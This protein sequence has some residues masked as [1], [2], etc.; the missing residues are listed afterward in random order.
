MP[1]SNLKRFFLFI[2]M[3]SILAI[4]LFI[5]SIF[6][7]ILPSFEKNIMEGKKEMIS[8][9]TQSVCS[10]IEEYQQEVTKGL[11]PLDSAQ[12]L[13]VE[14]ISQIRY[15]DE[16]KDY[17]WIIDKQPVMIMHPYRPELIGKDLNHYKDPDGKLVFV[18]SVAVV[19]KKGEGFIDYMWQRK[20]DSTRI[21]PKLSYVKEVQPWGWIVGTGIYLEDVRLEIGF[22]K[23]GLLRVALLI[24]LIISTILA[25]IIRQSLDIEK[26][27]RKAE[28][29]LRLSREKYKSLVEASTEG[30]LMLANQAFVFSNMKFSDLSG[31]D[32]AEVR[33][34]NFEQLF[35]VKWEMLASEFKDPKSS[36]SRETILKCKDGSQKEV[37]ISAS[38]ITY[39]GQ[40]G[41]ILVTKEVSSLMQFEKES[42]QLAVEL[43][44]SLSVMNQPLHS[45]AGEIW[46]CQADTSIRDAALLMSR[47]NRTILFIQ[48]NN[49]IIGVINNNDLN[50]RV[51]A[52][53]M[54]P[55]NRVIEIMTS[56]VV[57]L[58]GNAL[59]YEGILT[60]NAK[61]VSHI[62]LTGRDHTINGVVGY[63]ELVEM[64]QNMVGFLVRE[65]ENSETTDQISH[66]YRRLTALVKA[67]IESGSHTTN[68]TRIITKVAD[69]IHRRLMELALEELGPAPA[70]F[71]LMVM[72]S[73]GR[74]EQTLATDQDNAIIIGDHTGLNKQEVQ[75]YFLSLG[76]KINNDLRIVGYKKCPGEIMAGNPTWNQDLPTWKKYFSNWIQ[77]SN[78]RDI[79]DTAIFF[80]FRFIYG[81]SPLVEELR[82]HVN[83]TSEN[84]SVFFYHMAHAIMKMKPTASHQANEPMDLKKMLLPLTSFI[85][86]Y[87]IR[88]Q[89]IETGSMERAAL[90]LERKEIDQPT[91][92]ELTQSFNYLTYLRIRNQSAAIASNEIPTNSLYISSLT[93]I[94]SITLKKLI[95]DITGLQT[96]L[97]AEFTGPD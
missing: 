23:K 22:L 83:Q 70:R 30:T 32:P 42:G 55:G 63:K 39:A 88:A 10:L 20:D 62:A 21:V 85:R 35:D 95:T 36:I 19:S 74:G 65:L 89:M 87:A 38:Q 68:I 6:F 8:E 40:T 73:L 49:E 47:K 76:K 72:G 90:L 69:A 81:E 67:L 56:P 44:T 57:T 46:K 86:L 82:A 79:L 2:V 17:F 48:Q 9:L 25:F 80:D 58:P 93:R 84:K 71:A 66:I 59:L 5:A 14:R 27:R 53:G 52:T 60:M 12:A 7:V 31:Y 97:S 18:E 3:P 51:L 43:Q 11:I 26:R 29:D 24:S 50:R 41:Y 91:W 4:S 92:D 77:D 45:I 13:V 54:D 64:Q 1:Q 96:R 75:S 33:Q 78:P 94:E 61:S 15:G 28:N 34:M 37:V 16:L